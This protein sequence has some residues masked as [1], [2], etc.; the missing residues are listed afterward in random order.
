MDIESAFRTAARMNGEAAAANRAFVDRVVTVSTGALAISVTFRGEIAGGG[1]G[2][3]WLLQ[4]AWCALAFCSVAGVFMHRATVSAAR[5]FIDAA[6]RGEED[7]DLVSPPHEAYILLQR[8]LC[9]AFPL[10][11]AALAAFGVLNVGGA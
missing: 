4:G 9:L 3:V 2:H 1:A 5:R 6:A 10:G 11:M 7:Y 8:L